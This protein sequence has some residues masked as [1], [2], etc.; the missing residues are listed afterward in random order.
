MAG[1]RCLACVQQEYMSL[2][3]LCSAWDTGV[4]RDPLRGFL[5]VKSR[6]T[7]TQVAPGFVTVWSQ[8]TLFT[9]LSFS[10]LTYKRVHNSPHL[11]GP[12]EGSVRWWAHRLWHEAWRTVST[13]RHRYTIPSTRERAAHR[14]VGEWDV[15]T[16]GKGLCMCENSL[17][18]S[19][20]W[21]LMCYQG[22]WIIR[23]GPSRISPT[24][25]TLFMRDK[26]YKK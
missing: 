18:P 1:T 9:S 20:R 10:P 4:T 17:P 7:Q 23:M 24:M 3:G 6:V 21:S 12:C 13:I 2:R 25:L 26:S 11:S 16:G 19:T 8:V 5:K 14:W 15:M 22:S